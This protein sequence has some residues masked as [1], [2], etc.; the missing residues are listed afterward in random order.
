MMADITYWNEEIET[1]SPDR[2]RELQLSRIKDRLSYLHENSPFYQKKFGDAGLKPSAVQDLDDFRRLVPLTT[3]EELQEE[4]ERSRDPY[5][6]LLCVPPSEII[7]LIRT[8]GTTGVPTI[9]GVTQK[10]LQYIG[11]LSARMWYQIGARK[12]HT[13]A[14]ATFGSWNFFSLAL[15]EGLRTGGIKRY[16]F[17][18]PFPG[19]EVFPIEILPQWMDIE[20]IYLSSRP[21]WQV[22]EKYRGRL[23]ELLPKLHY[24]LMAGQHIT[25]SF[26]RGTESMWGGRLFD[27]YTMT[28]V[29]L[30]AASC[31]EQLE[32]FHFPEDAFFVEVIDPDTGDDLT[33]TGN[34]GEIVVS[35]LL[36]EGTPLLRF[37]SGD[38]GFTISGRCPCGRTGMRLGIAERI[39]HAIRIGD[40][41]VFSSEIEE[42]LYGFPE[43]FLRHYHLVR[44]KEQPQE[45][46]LLRVERPSDAS[47]QGRLKRDLI[48]SIR[49]KI[50]VSSEVEFISQDDERFVAAYKFL[51]VVTE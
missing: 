5:G 12:G 17:T 35:S 43:F 25:S 7:H 16:H 33:G 10:D 41:V 4:R 32:T 19:E 30:P 11:E 28:D 48:A 22:T 8:A 44:K 39:A 31:T 1:L 34:V 26:R 13:V 20:G 15:L 24:L 51:R 37:H 42:I 27:A 14:I 3:K 21:L 36:L 47:V 38:M 2:I 18:M 45:S 46:L 9:Y 40:R 6:G 23:K 49:E 50:G 29:G